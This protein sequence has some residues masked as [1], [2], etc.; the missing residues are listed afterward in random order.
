MSFFD[1]LTQIG[2]KCV[3][4]GTIGFDDHE[5]LKRKINYEWTKPSGGKERAKKSAFQ[6]DFFFY[7]QFTLD[8]SHDRCLPTANQVL[9]ALPEEL[10][11]PKNNGSFKNVSVDA[12]LLKT[13]IQ[14]TV[15]YMYRDRVNKHFKEEAEAK[16]KK[17]RLEEDWDRVQAIYDDYAKDEAVV[18]EEAAAKRMRVESL[19]TIEGC[20]VM[21]RALPRGYKRWNDT[22][23]DRAGLALVWEKALLEDIT[24][25][26]HDAFESAI[27]IAEATDAA[28]ASS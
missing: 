10:Q 2:I 17:R 28:K 8:A 21:L 24:H 9:E 16:K 11:F 4:T 25:E 18:A 23:N 6:R 20:I 26:A 12:D 27:S 15:S 13:P 3:Q 7:W 22:G 5:K 19:K 1:E 14:Y